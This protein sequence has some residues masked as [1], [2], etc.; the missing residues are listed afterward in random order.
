[1]CHYLV[2]IMISYYFGIDPTLLLLYT[3][4]IIDFVIKTILFLFPQVPIFT[5]PLGI[6][7]SLVYSPLFD[8][9]ATWS[10]QL[11]SGGFFPRCCHDDLLSKLWT[12]EGKRFDSGFA[13]P[14]PRERTLLLWPPRLFVLHRHEAVHL[15][16][17]DLAFI[18]FSLSLL[19]VV[20]YGVDFES[21][22]C[23][24]SKTIWKTEVFRFVMILMKMPSLRQLLKSECCCIVCFRS[25]S[26][27][28]S[29]WFSIFFC[30]F[31]SNFAVLCE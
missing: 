23:S 2:V 21:C 7:R 8:A 24:L 29:E 17:E 16:S 27:V 10:T 22:L 5:S 28:K 30:L 31:R 25:T 19:F 6:H 14:S 1:M 9:I 11:A 13:A 20:D 26:V 3:V 15:F 4:S 12:T 18:C